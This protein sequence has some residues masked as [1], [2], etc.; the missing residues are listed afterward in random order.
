[1]SFKPGV[2]RYRHSYRLSQPERELMRAGFLVG[3]TLIQ[4]LRWFIT[5]RKDLV[6]R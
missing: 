5:F 1:M 4:R 3:S 2:Y 6:T